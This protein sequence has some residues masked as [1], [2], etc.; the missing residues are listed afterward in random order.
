[1][2]GL[3][4]A[5]IACTETCLQEVRNVTRRP[6][7]WRLGRSRNQKCTTKSDVGSG[8][9][10]KESGNQTEPSATKSG[11]YATRRKPRA[12]LCLPSEGKAVLKDR[13]CNGTQTT[14]KT[15][16]DLSRSVTAGL[17]L[18]RFTRGLKGF[19]T[20]FPVSL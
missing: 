15:T 16:P 4:G 2:K 9:K 11:T 18:Q 10:N 14:A 13:A 19:R 17:L 6:R 20:R 5:F 3:L 8:A 12:G 7:F 1:M